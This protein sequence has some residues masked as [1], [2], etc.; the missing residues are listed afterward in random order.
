M[1]NDKMEQLTQLGIDMESVMERFMNNDK[2][3]T[4]FMLKFLEDTN[5]DRF[6]QAMKDEDTQAAFAAAHTIK[7][8]CKNLS[9]VSMDKTFS[10]IT[11]LL[12]AGDMEKAKERIPEAEDVYSKTVKIIKD[13]F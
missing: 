11:E 2:M 7:G 4:K 13:N 1:D 5:I 12:R 8:L 6:R 9:L 10:E 3:V